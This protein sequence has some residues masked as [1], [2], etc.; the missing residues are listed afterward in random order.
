MGILSSIFGKAESVVKFA[1]PITS[2]A[3]I[4]ER[5][6]NLVNQV[7]AIPSVWSGKSE[8]K[9]GGGLLP[10]VA[11]TAVEHPIITV[12]TIVGGAYL[13]SSTAARAAVVTG[14]KTLATKHP[15][16]AT[17][18]VLASPIIVPAAIGLAKSETARETILD[19]PSK[20]L[21]T[22]ST[23]ATILDKLAS[24]KPLTSAEIKQLEKWGAI[25]IGAG[26]TAYAAWKLYKT[27]FPEYYKEVGG[28]KPIEPQAQVPQ[29]IYIS[30][31]IAATPTSAPL[32][33]IPKEVEAVAPTTAP[34]SIKKAAKKKKKK[35]KP[36][37][38]KKAVKKAKKKTKPKKK[39]KSLKTKKKKRSK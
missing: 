34:I 28:D 11:K 39:A 33:T 25:G 24:K 6:V 3:G 17:G 26:V 12:G 20:S 31:P 14:I 2:I 1:N 29:N 36:K 16:L 9:S 10:T 23:A 27:M 7:K 30:N 32:L 8:V 37:P 22:G 19:L 4:K 38:K 13:A 15:L 21:E 35:A 5:A 18:A